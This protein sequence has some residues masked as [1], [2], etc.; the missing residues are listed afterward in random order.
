[1]VFLFS[2][3]SCAPVISKELR[4]QVAAGVTFT[5]VSR[6]PDLYAGKT[7]LWAGVIL[8][9]ENTKDGTLLEILQTPAGFRGSPGDIYLSK[10][11]FLALN[12]GGH[13]DASIY[14]KGRGITVAGEIQGVGIPLLPSPPSSQPHYPLILAKEIHPWPGKNRDSIYNRKYFWAPWGL[15]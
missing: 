4:E 6:N 15:P 10:G 14:T 13:L 11:R 8:K 12:E 7:V 5:E 1:M 3:S 2:S 9:G